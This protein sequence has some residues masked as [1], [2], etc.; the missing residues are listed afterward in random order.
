MKKVVEKLYKFFGAPRARGAHRDGALVERAVRTALAAVGR[1]VV[2][3]P[4]VWYRGLMAGPSFGWGLAWKRGGRWVVYDERRWALTCPV[5][6]NP[7][8]RVHWWRSSDGSLQV[9]ING[10]PVPPEEVIFR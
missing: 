7:P 1:V 4:V 10:Q 9:R 5:L 2:R 3:M 8:A 6:S